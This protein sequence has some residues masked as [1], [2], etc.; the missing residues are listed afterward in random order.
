MDPHRYSSGKGANGYHYLPSEFAEQAAEQHA[1]EQRRRGPVPVRRSQ[2]SRKGEHGPAYQ[3]H[4]PEMAYQLR[5]MGASKRMIAAACY[6]TETTIDEWMNHP[7]KAIPEFAE[8]M[9]AGGDLADSMVAMS[10]HHRAV[11][12][13]HDDT[14]VLVVDKEVVEVPIIKHY[15]PDTEAGKFWLT[16]R[17]HKNW[18]NRNTQ[19]LS[20]PDGQPLVPPQ[21]VVLP[22]EPK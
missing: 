20:G 18:R 6:V 8:A 14:K 5:L 4:F 12:Y 21:L 22:V 11:G 1:A 9:R 17:Q 15:P 16:N 13:S 2:P 19:E 7:D 10:L 3:P